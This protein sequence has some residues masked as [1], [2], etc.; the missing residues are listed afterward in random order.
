MLADAVAQAKD[1]GRRRRR[2]HGAPISSI[3]S[4]IART[5]GWTVCTVEARAAWQRFCA[6]MA[7][8]AQR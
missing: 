4:G 7:S 1:R 5:R 8:R 2:I 6:T 3:A